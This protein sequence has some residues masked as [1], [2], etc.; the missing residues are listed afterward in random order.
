MYILVEVLGDTR[1][2]RGGYSNIIYKAGFGAAHQ[3]A[4]ELCM[5]P[6]VLNPAAVFCKRGQR[7]PARAIQIPVEEIDLFPVTS[8][9]STS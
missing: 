5:S 9:L 3:K 4:V 7:P 6:T 1:R 2:V 8:P